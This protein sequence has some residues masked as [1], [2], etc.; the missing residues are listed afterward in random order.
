[1]RSLSLAAARRGAPLQL[2]VRRRGDEFAAR[3]VELVPLDLPVDFKAPD[4]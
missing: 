1:M 2:S 4:P 3:G